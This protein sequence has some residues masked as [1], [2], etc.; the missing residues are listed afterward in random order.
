MPTYSDGAPFAHSSNFLKWLAP[1]IGSPVWG[2][3]I[4]SWEGRSALWLI[5]NVLTHPQSRLTCVDTWQ[6]EAMQKVEGMDFALKE[7]NFLDNTRPYRESG[8]LIVRKGESAKIVRILVKRYSFAYIDGS[9][10]APDVLIDAVNVWNVL[11]PGGVMIFDDY[12]WHPEQNR[13]GET[14]EPKVAIDAFLCVFRE[15]IEILDKGYQV[16]VRKVV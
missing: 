5:E 3:E 10:E 6:G 2:L 13:R 9:H 15:R 8:R 11:V 12:E 7:L 14:H 16:A 4:G 1:F